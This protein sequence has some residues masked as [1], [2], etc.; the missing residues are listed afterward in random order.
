VQKFL[1]VAF[2]TQCNSE[3]FQSGQIEFLIENR[4]GIKTTLAVSNICMTNE[5]IN[6]L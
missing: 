5:Y 4:E 6:L 1:Q 3:K 2:K